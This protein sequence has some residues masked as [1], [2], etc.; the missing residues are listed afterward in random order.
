MSIN[1]GMDK[2]VVHGCNG[3]LLSHEKK[4][5]S[6]IYRMY[7][8]KGFDMLT[9]ESQENWTNFYSDQQNMRSTFPTPLPTM[10]ISKLIFFNKLMHACQVAS[11]MS[12][13]VRPYGQQPTRLLCPRDSLGKNTD[14]GCHFLLHQQADR[15]KQ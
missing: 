8:C 9:N 2:D 6:T 3:I 1:R 12:A 13:S 10:R 5:N 7:F 14:V 11:V 15:G 4:W